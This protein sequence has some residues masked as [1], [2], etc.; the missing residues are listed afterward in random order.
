MHF[1]LYLTHSIQSNLILKS[2][3]AGFSA[4]LILR[5]ETETTT[6]CC[7]IQ[8]TCK[9]N[10]E[11]EITALYVIGSIRSVE[12]HRNDKDY[13][14]TVKA[15]AANTHV[16][17]DAIGRAKSLSLKCFSATPGEFLL[18]SI[19][20]VGR[21]VEV[22]Q[23]EVSLLCVQICCEIFSQIA[24]FRFMQINARESASNAKVNQMLMMALSRGASGST[25]PSLPFIAPVS[26]SIPSSMLP[27]A[28]VA[29]TTPTSPTPAASGGSKD[30]FQSA[31]L[32]FLKDMKQEIMGKLTELDN[33]VGRI[34][35][36]IS[37]L[38]AP[39]PQ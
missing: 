5:A 33:R 13:L 3:D 10:E 4:E 19:V 23:Q 27:A 9:H 18:R 25:T 30:D 1:F 16:K 7:P 29:P 14:G 36:Q 22:S 2:S 26:S 37:R 20:V 35:D 15:D 24:T 34:E 38:A 12:I 32:A 39:Q 21:L 31:I 28:S 17:I 11:L 8:I 6:R